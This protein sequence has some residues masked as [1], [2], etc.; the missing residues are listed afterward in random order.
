[1]TIEQVPDEEPMGA[2]L[3]LQRK[4]ELLALPLSRSGAGRSSKWLSYYPDGPL[5][6][7]N[8]TRSTCP[9]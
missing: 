5:R 7:E 4:R 1:M 3:S 8:C 2:S 6:R 9:F